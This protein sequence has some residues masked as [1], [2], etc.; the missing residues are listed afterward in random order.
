MKNFKLIIEYDGTHYHGWQ[1]Q[2]KDA[3]IQGEIEDAIR[4]MT[5][6]RVTLYGS[7]RTDAGVHARGQTANFHCDTDLKPEVI[8]R[9]LNSLLPDD[10]VIKQCDQVED[11]F[12]ARYSAKSKIYDYTIANH[13]VPPAIN[14][15][16]VWSIRSQLD[17]MAMQSAIRCIVGSHDFKAFEGTGSPRAHTTRQVLAAGLRESDDRFLTFR[18]EADGFLRFMVRNI[19]GTLVDVGLGKTLPTEFRQI[20]ESRD[21]TKAGATAPARGL[22][23]MKV[24]Y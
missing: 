10:I 20:L 9:G 17:T 11:A 3:T 18:I 8:Q 13:P 4:T 22:C 12:H 2:K 6:T 7:G 23:L 15:Q 5:H 1:R 16:Y 24:K 19:V 14:R 21:R